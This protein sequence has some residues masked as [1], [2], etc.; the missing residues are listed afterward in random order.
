M[1]RYVGDYKINRSIQFGSL[2]ER[3][4]QFDPWYEGDSWLPCC[5]PDE[6]LELPQ[7]DENLSYDL[8]K[9]QNE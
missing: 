5:Q 9:V 6:I 8:F 4:G 7:F 3:Y 1:E 2:H